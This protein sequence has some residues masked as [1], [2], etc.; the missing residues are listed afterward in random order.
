[1]WSTGQLYVTDLE[2]DKEFELS[3]LQVN[4]KS[5]QNWTDAFFLIH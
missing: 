4:G 3:L 5:E 2:Y 1:M